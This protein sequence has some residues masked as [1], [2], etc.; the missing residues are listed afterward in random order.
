MVGIPALDLWD[1]V[2]EVFRSS[3]NPTKKTKDERESRENLSA[4]TTKTA[5]TDSYHAH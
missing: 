2:I 1:L 4:K 5:E 3:P